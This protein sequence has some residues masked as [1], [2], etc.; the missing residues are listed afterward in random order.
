MLVALSPPPFGACLVFSLTYMYTNIPGF[1]WSRNV[2]HTVVA[3]QYV[4]AK[5]VMVVLSVQCFLPAASLY[6]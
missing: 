3:S 2:F 4:R 5:A 1:I 6:R